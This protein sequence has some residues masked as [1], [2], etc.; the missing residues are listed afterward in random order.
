MKRRCKQLDGAERSDAASDAFHAWIR[1]LPWVVERPVAYLEPG[2]RAFAIACEPLDIHQMLLVT[3]MTQSRRIAVILPSADA[4]RYDDMGFGD[5]IAA[6]S[7][8]HVLFGVCDDTA[9]I[10]VERV[11]LDAYGSA[12]S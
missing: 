1:S 11:I 10:D 2:M 3:G 9:E 7:T 8:E 12:L 6:L 5:I 4:E